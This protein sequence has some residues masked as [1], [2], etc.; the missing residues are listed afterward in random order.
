MAG[1]KSNVSARETAY[2]LIRS[3]IINLDLKPND[4]L[5]EKELVEEM[6]MSRTPIHEAII[7]LSLEHLVSVRPQSSTFVAPIDLK[8][9]GIEQ[10][11]RCAVEKEIARLACGTLQE[12]HRQMYEENLQ[13]YQ[14]YINSQSPDRDHQLFDLDNAFHRIAFTVCGR[15]EYFDWMLKSFQH[16]ERIRILS[17]RMNIAAYVKDDHE[18]LT[19][20]MLRGDVGQVGELLDMHLK[21]YQ[22]DLL[23]IQKRYPYYFQT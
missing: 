14:I 8:M 13:L 11:N 6:G 22:D 17:L 3:R 23:P 20:A 15:G 1:T 18:Q 21:R 4:V 7:M 12:E 9:V 19:Q 2:Q 5:N 10:F 16:I